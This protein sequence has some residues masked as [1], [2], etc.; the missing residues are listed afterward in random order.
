MKTLIRFG[1]M[2]VL[3]LM[4]GAVCFGQHYAQ[5]NL[6][7]NT[8][9]VAPVTDP[10]LVNPWGISRGSG[11]PWWISHGFIFDDG[12][13]RSVDDP[14]GIGTTT[15]NGVKSSDFTWPP[16]GTR[17]DSSGLGNREIRN[18]WVH[19]GSMPGPESRDRASPNK[20]RSKV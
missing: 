5:T 15:I 20:L 11:S 14:Q 6:V 19:I 12:E 8:S 17:M 18:Q 13:F 16:V 2:A 3:T 4:M 10:Q 9:G 7:S 1:T